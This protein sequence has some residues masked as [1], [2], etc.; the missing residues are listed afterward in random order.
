MSYGCEMSCKKSKD[1]VCWGR[2][3]QQSSHEMSVLEEREILFFQKS[4][5]NQNLT[6]V[7]THICNDPK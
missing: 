3:I 2:R 1:S 6:I 7:V 5:A 4:D